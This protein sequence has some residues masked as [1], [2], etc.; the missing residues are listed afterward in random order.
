MNSQKTHMSKA[1][2]I[3]ISKHFLKVIKKLEV[4]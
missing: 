2:L 1:G 4:A 3:P